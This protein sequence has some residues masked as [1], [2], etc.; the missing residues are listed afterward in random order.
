[1]NWDLVWGGLL[2]AGFAAFLPLELLG[3]KDDGRGKHYGTFSAAL[4][5]WGGIEPKAKRRWVFGP[6]FALLLAWF[7]V[8][9]L[10]PW[11]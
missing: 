3:L 10:T 6:M 9:I 8:H 1:M 7:G 2:T 5:R 11:L 4:R